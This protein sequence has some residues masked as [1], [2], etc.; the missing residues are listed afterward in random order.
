MLNGEQ[1]GPYTLEELPDAGVYP[2]T[3]VWCKD[4]KDWQKAEEVAEI[5]RLFRQRL[6]G[7]PGERQLTPEEE[8]RRQQEADLKARQ[9]NLEQLPMRYRQQVEESGT[10]F[11]PPVEQQPDYSRPPKFYFFES[12]LAAI[13]CFLF[14]G[15]IAVY[16]SWRAKKAWQN[17]AK[18][19]S[20]DYA[21][22]ARMWLGITFFMG[23]IF[24]GYTML[25]VSR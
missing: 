22:Y 5:C 6:I 4:M 8:A 25:T 19:E 11:T 20:Y 23:V 3:Y 10:D 18:E 14:T 16:F 7:V 9:E 24:L 13:F 17:G 12:I 15:I 21:G 2:D 1:K